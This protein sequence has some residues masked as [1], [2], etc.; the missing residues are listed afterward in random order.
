MN[1]LNFANVPQSLR[2]LP[3][4]IVWR[5]ESRG[6]KPTKIPFQISGSHAKSDDPDTWASFCEVTD[7]ARMY[8]GIGFVFSADDP[9]CGI[10]LDGC[11]DP[12]T[13]NVSEWAREIILDMDTYAE[14]SPS[15]TGVKL[16]VVGKPPIKNG[17]KASVNGVEKVGDKE[18]GIEVY[19]EKRYFAVTGWRLR[20]PHEPQERQE[21]LNALCERFFKEKAQATSD[22]WYSDAAVIERAR[23]YLATL[24]GAVSGRSGHNDTF[25]AACVLV[26]G[27]CLSEHAAL[28]LMHEYN[29]RCNP[30]WTE[31]ELIHKVKQAGKQSGQRGY[32]RLAAVDRW[33][34]IAVPLYESP[35]PKHEPRVTTIHQAAYE[36]VARLKTGEQEL[37]EFGITDLDYALGGGVERGEFIVFAARPSHGKSAVALQ[38]IHFWTGQGRPCLIVSEEMSSL[39]LGKRTLQFVSNVPQEHWRDLPGEIEKEID[40]YGATHAKCVILEG[41]GDAATAVRAI[42]ESIERDNIQCVVVDYAQL[43]RGVGKTRYEQQTAVSIAL[44]QLATKHKVVLLALC[45]MS[46]EVEHRKSFQPTMSDLKETGQFEQDA[47]V[48]V[49]LCWPWRINQSEPKCRY[50]FFVEKNRN[51]GINQR[52]IDCTF[53]PLRQRFTISDIETP[54]VPMSSMPWQ[55]GV[56]R[57]I[58]D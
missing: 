46:R 18:P 20:G 3:Q 6:D 36:Y 51:R 9:Y 19:F 24:P 14:V 7:V 49:F 29:Q 4:W 10:D 26:L 53:D 42:E 45:Q 54:S 39:A 23:K 2:S 11:R 25:H 38:C 48:I 21:K 44:R 12:E 52:G 58:P 15:K 35:Q 17:R 5:L 37:I 28:A 47:D 31:K 16:W 40:Q 33:S 8:S 13:G 32:L 1:E 30:P 50:Q 34:S 43:L 56:D 57:V 27:F 55:A 41:C 22:D